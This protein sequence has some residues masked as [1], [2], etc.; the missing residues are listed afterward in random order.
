RHTLVILLFVL[1]LAFYVYGALNLDFGINEM[2]ALF[3]VIA[4]GSGIIAKLNTTEFVTEF[5]NGARNLMYAAL[6]TGAARAVVLVL[7]DGKIID[8]VIYSFSLPLE[9]LPPSLSA[10]GMLWANALFNFFVNSG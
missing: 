5:M 4:I 8:T 3:L 7:E 1:S 10:I 6:I 9:H 2:S